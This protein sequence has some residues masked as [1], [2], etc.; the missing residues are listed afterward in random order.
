M[1]RKNYSPKKP[2]S[3]DN[4]FASLSQLHDL[5]EGPELT[6]SENQAA[7]G[8]D[9][10]ASHSVPLRV[11][12]DRKYRRGKAATLVTGYTGDAET[13]EALGKR[14]K[15][16]CGVGGSVKDGVIIIQG[17]QRDRLMELLVEYGYNNTK[18][19]GGVA[20]RSHPL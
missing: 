10:G 15:I 11:S 20:G 5:P 3:Q 17:D 16:S 1:A 8:A 13:L 2:T 14:L 4:P 6:P 19:S 18:S 9:A 12:V 7:L